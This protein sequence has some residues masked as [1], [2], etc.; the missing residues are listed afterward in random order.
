MKNQMTS[1]QMDHWKH[2]KHLVC[3]FEVDE[4]EKKRKEKPR[5]LIVLIQKMIISTNKFQVV[6]PRQVYILYFG[7]DQLYDRRNVEKGLGRI[8]QECH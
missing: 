6:R 5:P 1:L 4:Q 8:G 2:L 7:R 3:I